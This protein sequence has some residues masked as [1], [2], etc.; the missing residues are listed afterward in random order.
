MTLVIERHMHPIANHMA[1][2]TFQGVPI[3]VSH[4]C[5]LA[6][7]IDESCDSQH[8]S[9]CSAEDQTSEMQKCIVRVHSL[10]LDL[11]TIYSVTMHDS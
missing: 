5:E 1:C 6:E 4:H 10:L 11:T 8:K 2:G 7:Q 3:T 9:A